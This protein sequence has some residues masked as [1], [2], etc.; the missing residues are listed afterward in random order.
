MDRSTFYRLARAATASIAVAVFGSADGPT[1]GNSAAVAEPRTADIWKKR[2]EGFVERSKK[3][4][5]D[6]LFAGD[7][8]TQRWET[9]GKAVWDDTV[10][11]W[12]PAN[13]GIGGDRTQH[14][15]WRIT[16]GKELVGI[17]PKVV[18]LLIGTNN[19]FNNSPAEI[20]GG[21]RAILAE[22]RKQKPKAEILLLG[23]F[24]RAG[25]PIPERASVAPSGELNPKVAEVNALL[26]KLE[27][28]AAVTFLDLGGRFLDDRGNLPRKMMPDFV[29]LSTEGYRVWAGAITQPI[30]DLL[31]GR[32]SPKRQAKASWRRV[33]A[34]RERLMM[35]VSV[36]RP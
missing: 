11:A 30:D 26:A 18:V 28:D 15:L 19:L 10:A 12:K 2:H 27:D 9:D 32:P 6:V 35:W 13:L 29:H 22:F 4:N 34:F 24:P 33:D 25:Q 20:A 17:E 7:S 1:S 31:A 14:L 3:G 16:A 5:V 36:S 21:V 23:L 8:I